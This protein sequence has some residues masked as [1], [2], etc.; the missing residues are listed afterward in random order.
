MKKVLLSVLSVVVL[1]CA[2]LSFQSFT[3]KKQSQTIKIYNNSKWDIDHIYIS[4]IDKESW[5]ADLLGSDEVMTPGEYITIKVDC[6]IYDVKIVDEDGVV[7]QLADVTICDG[8]SI[9]AVGDL[10]KCK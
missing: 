5:G 9:W 10:T 4:H 3:A 6:N 8:D 2:G 1:G 7:C